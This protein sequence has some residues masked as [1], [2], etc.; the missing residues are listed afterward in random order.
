MHVLH[1]FRNHGFVL[2]VF[3]AVGIGL[4]RP[5]AVQTVLTGAI[6]TLW[7][8]SIMFVIVGLT[9]PTEQIGNGLR[10]MKLHV[11]VQC[12]IFVISPLY[13]AST[14][15]LFA[16]VLG[17]GF[18]VG[19]YAL[20]VLPTTV[21]SC[22]VL[23]QTT[24]GNTVG[25]IFNSVVANILGVFL[26]PVLLSWLLQTGG[27]G[28]PPGEIV[29]VV[30][31]LALTMLAPIALG[32]VLRQ[33]IGAA[34]AGRQR[35]LATVSQGLIL[36]VVAF[37]VARSAETTRDAFQSS[38]IVAPIIYIALSH[39]ILLAIVYVLARVFGLD[40]GTRI[41]VVFA[42]P[43][44]TLAVGA[45]LLS[46]Y[47]AHTPDVLGVAL[48]PLLFYHVWQLVVAGFVRSTFVRAA[49]REAG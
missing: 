43:Q 29:R 21:S 25:T 22:I 41:A 15:T 3:A 13:F 28:L 34:V 26:T 38:A 48:L 44:K 47:F 7:I 39:L 12:S 11:L 16:A 2:G 1:W 18:T 35:L 10:Q 37:S 32:Q 9:L 20:S 49:R 4:W 30:R 42:A 33:R 36:C 8:P 40:R 19:V 27:R 17:E 14:T 46:T 24:G 45:P 6:T 5:T 23:T 31:S